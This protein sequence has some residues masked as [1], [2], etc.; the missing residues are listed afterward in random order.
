MSHG[1]HRL[2]YMNQGSYNSLCDKWQLSLPLLLSEAGSHSSEE[3]SGVI[4]HGPCSS[5]V[6]VS[7]IMSARRRLP[8]AEENQGWKPPAT[9]KLLCV[10]P[11]PLSATPCRSQ[12]PAAHCAQVSLPTLPPQGEDNAPQK[13]HICLGSLSESGM[14]WQVLI[15]DS[16]PLEIIPSGG[17]VRTMSVFLESSETGG[18][19]S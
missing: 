11:S 4:G 18:H 6:T 1:I 17:H 3:G 14:C 12:C 2:Y 13:S 10:Q 15:Q 7:S 8:L 16:V 5:K 19:P 9:F